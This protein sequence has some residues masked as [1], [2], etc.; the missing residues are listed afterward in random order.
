MKKL[1]LMLIGIMLLSSLA[2]AATVVTTKET[3]CC[4]R[5]NN[6]AWCQNTLP[7]NCDAS[8]S[9]TPSSCD[10]TSFCKLGTCY[11]SSEGTCAEKTSQKACSQSGGVW[12]EGDPDSV[13]QCQPACCVLG[14]Q[15]AFTTLT[16][17]KK[18]SS[19]YGLDTDFRKNIA[20]E[21]ECVAVTQSKD[22]GACTYEVD[23]IKTC[24]FTTRSDCSKIASSA[25]F[26]DFL[27]SAD[28]LATNCG[29]STKTTCLPNKD[30]VYFL[31]T[32]GNPA[33]IYDSTRAADKSYW[34]MVVQ[35]A[36]SCSATNADGNANSQSCG[37]CQY[38][39]GSICKDYRSTTTKVKPALGN[40]ICQDLD[41]SSTFNS[42][43]YKHGE[44][45]CVNDNNNPTEGSVG[46]R[47]YRHLCI[48]GEEIVEPCADFR[49]E[50]C[51]Q[52]AIDTSAG[53]FSQA[54]CVVNRWQTCSKQKTK[55]SCENPDVRDCKWSASRSS[56][57]SVTGVCVPSVAPGLE[58]W[59]DTEAN[60]ICKQASEICV[61]EFEIGLLGGEECVSN[62]HCLDKNWIESKKDQCTALG[63]CGSKVN[64]IKVKG[65][66]KGYS[67]AQKLPSKKAANAETA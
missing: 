55:S 66:G 58:F 29:P 9:S 26:K 5:T 38:F 11:D 49:N 27:C 19:Q 12:S 42:N 2:L 40:Y 56:D 22:E 63:D 35:K 53:P 65:H 13:P 46:S 18:L 52:D 20:S 47:H 32:C 1:L 57:G 50:V 54:G 30:E 8:Y 16:R 44:S 36:D 21:S 25:F 10:A 3:V 60:T 34:R 23:F 31:D 61:V 62:C 39:A 64:V 45:W 17:C 7:S 14:D 59:Q 41:C 51:L 67:T 33:N 24:K 4:E 6:G 28:D 37:N 15:A 48:A 43:S